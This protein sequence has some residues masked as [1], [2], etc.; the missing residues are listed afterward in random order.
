MVDELVTGKSGDK[1]DYGAC[2]E[3]WRRKY[4]SHANRETIFSVFVDTL[5]LFEGMRI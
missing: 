5:F 2:D 4:G 3:N 1:D